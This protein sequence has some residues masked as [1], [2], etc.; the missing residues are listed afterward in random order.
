[1]KPVLAA[2]KQSPT[3]K[4]DREL[5]LGFIFFPALSNALCFHF[6]PNRRFRQA[7]SLVLCL[8]A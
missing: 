8:I 3:G 7:E 4:Q 1:M 2:G 6:P 5:N